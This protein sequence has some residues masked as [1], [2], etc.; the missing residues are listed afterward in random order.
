MTFEQ[1]VAA[2]PDEYLATPKEAF[3]FGVIEG[4]AAERERCASIAR[5]TIS[6]PRIGEGAEIAYRQREEIAKRIEAC[7]SG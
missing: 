1:W 3:D 7:V 2:H 6:V 5:E 4:A